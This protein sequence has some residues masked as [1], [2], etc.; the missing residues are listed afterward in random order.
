MSRWVGIL[1]IGLSPIIFGEVWGDILTAKN[2]VASEDFERKAK[3]YRSPVVAVSGIIETFDERGNPALVL[4]ERWNPP[5]GKALPGGMVEYGESLETAL[6]REMR[7]ETGLEVYDV[8]QFHAYSDP[9]RDDRFH[10]IDVVH[11]AQCRGVPVA[12][13]DARKVFI[14]PLTDIPWSQLVFD[15][16]A[17]IRDYLKYRSKCSSSSVASEKNTCSS[18]RKSD[19][20]STS[21]LIS[22]R[23]FLLDH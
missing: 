1:G 11:L 15:H 10:V 21:G 5:L 13:T 19:G 17:I 4:V 7:E 8:R 16:A 22:E 14:Y 12:N 18:N 23:G 9:K 2:Q 3:A 6:G 20:E